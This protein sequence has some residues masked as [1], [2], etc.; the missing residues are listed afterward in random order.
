MV[1]ETENGTINILENNEIINAPHIQKFGTPVAVKEFLINNGLTVCQAILHFQKNLLFGFVLFFKFN[2]LRIQADPK[3]NLPLR[4][5]NEQNH[6]FTE[7]CLNNFVIKAYKI[8]AFVPFAMHIIVAVFF[9]NSFFKI[10][11][12]E[13]LKH[14]C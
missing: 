9:K 1:N 5:G 4:S 13:R 7:R 3:A 2:V 8:S 6:I 11:L 12:L 14:F 10:L